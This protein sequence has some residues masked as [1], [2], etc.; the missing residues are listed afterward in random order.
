MVYKRTDFT[1]ID[2]PCA[3]LNDKNI[4]I[5]GRVAEKIISGLYML[6]A[7]AVMSIFISIETKTTACRI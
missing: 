3:F 5:K 6:H 2:K 1:S 7:S 4:G